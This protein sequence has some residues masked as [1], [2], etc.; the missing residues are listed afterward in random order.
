M[1]DY[2]LRNE[3]TEVRTELSRTAARIAP[4]LDEYPGTT[5]VDGVCDVI[6]MPARRA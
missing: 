3:M 5:P 4:L 2:A 6:R 1:I